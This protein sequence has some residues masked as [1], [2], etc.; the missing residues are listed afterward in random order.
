MSAKF[1]RQ[2]NRPDQAEQKPDDS[3]PENQLSVL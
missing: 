1:G 2:W 3:A